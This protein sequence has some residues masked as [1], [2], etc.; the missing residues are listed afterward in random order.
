MSF[1]ATHLIGFG[2][3]RSSSATPTRT[4]I[5]EYTL[6]SAANTTFTNT[7]ASLGTAA[8]GRRVMVAVMAYVGSG[9]PTLTGCTINGQ[10]ATIAAQVNGT[11]T[12]VALAIAQVDSGATG[13]IVFTWSSNVQY[14]TTYVWSISNLTTTTAHATLTDN[15]VAS[16]ELTGTLNVPANG[17]VFAVAGTIDGSP[18]LPTWSAGV[19]G[20]DNTTN[21]GATAAA[22]A[23]ASYG[24]AQTPLTVTAGVPASSGR[25]CLAVASYGN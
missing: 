3:K 19:T 7:G 9:T 13:D 21:G 17:L 14:I 24:S 25:S 20:D 1:A 11:N 22:C 8:T 5:A 4:Y 18:T 23:S 10:T 16:S 15:T 2:G 12:F 6:S